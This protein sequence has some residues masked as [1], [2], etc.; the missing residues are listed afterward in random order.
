[1]AV[2]PAHFRR[3]AGRTAIAP[4]GARSRLKSY[5]LD[6]GKPTVRRPLTALP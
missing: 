3:Q 2:K 5:A 1:L 4:D 6:R